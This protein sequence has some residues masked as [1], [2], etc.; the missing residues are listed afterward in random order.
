MLDWA[1]GKE[2]LVQVLLGDAWVHL[3]KEDFCGL[4]DLGS[5]LLGVGS[6]DSD[7]PVVDGVGSEVEDSLEGFFV[8]AEDDGAAF[9]LAGDPVD[10]EV[11]V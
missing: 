11:Y 6:I 7:L 5:F 2:E 4:D 3:A 1:V 10:D 9:G 8:G